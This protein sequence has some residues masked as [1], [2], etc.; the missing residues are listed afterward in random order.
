MEVEP[1][2][3]PPGIRL[4]LPPWRRKESGMKQFK[5]WQDPANAVLGGWLILSP[6][7]LGFDGL[8]IAVTTT[9]FIGALLLAT[10]LGAMSLPQAW[11][12]W[13]DVALGAALMVSP[14]ILGFDGAQVAVQ[15]ALFTGLAVAALSLWVLATDDDLGGWWHRLVG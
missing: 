10:N 9:V 8:M 11:E 7:I 5:H 15:N 14:W 4:A 13:A 12:E 2:P 1:H 6:W 3:A